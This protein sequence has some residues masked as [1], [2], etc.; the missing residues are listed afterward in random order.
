MYRKQVRRRRA[1]LVLLVGASLILLTSTFGGG[2]G[3]FITFQHGLATALGPFEE[4]ASRALKPAR[5]LVNWFHETF[6]ARGENDQLK[7]EVRSLAIRKTQYEQAISENRKFRS[8]LGL[9]SANPVT[10]YKP[11]TSRII[12]RSPTV[13]YSSVTLDSGSGAGVRVNDP[14]ITGDG[15]VGHVSAVTRG[16]SEV[17]LITDHTSAVSTQVLPNGAQ[18]VVEPEAGNP[19]VLL[20]DFIHRSANIRRGQLVVTAGWSTGHLASAYP[21]GLRVGRITQVN[22]G[23]GQS[24][25][26]VNLRAFAD[27]RDMDYVQVLTNGPKRPGVGG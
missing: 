13:W 20:L 21:Y 7:A 26:K 15:L 19:N 23:V 27:L 22:R 4:G 6:N 11:V 24:Y 25:Q 5:D 8:M 16:T 18:G 3:P 12:G 1:V 9:D 17:T 2:G 10:A 14:V